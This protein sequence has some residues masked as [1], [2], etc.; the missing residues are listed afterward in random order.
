L[1]FFYSVGGHSS[2]IEHIGSR[3]MDFRIERE[4]QLEYDTELEPFLQQLEYDPATDVF[5]INNAVFV[6]ARATS[7]VSM[8]PFQGHSFGRERP[9]WIDTPPAQIGGF[10][11]GIGVASRHSSHRDTVVK[12]YESAVLGIIESMNSNVAGGQESYVNNYSAFGFGLT[13]SN[14]TTAQGMLRNFYI[15]ETW[16]DPATLEVWTLAVASKAGP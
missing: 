9:A 12:S 16:S 10:A 3:E 15:I 11:V 6:V 8:P 4:Y 1:S 7:G 5:E 14:V 2:R 13:T